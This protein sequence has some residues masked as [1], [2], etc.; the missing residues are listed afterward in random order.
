MNRIKYISSTFWKPLLTVATLSMLLVMLVVPTNLYAQKSAISEA[1]KALQANELDKSRALM[2]SASTHPETKDENKTWYY[3]AWVYKKLYSAKEAE[4]KESPYRL[5]AINSFKR[6][7]ELDTVS[8]LHE[9]AFKSTKYLASTLYNDAATSLNEGEFAL[10]QSNF[11]RYKDATLIIEPE[12]DFTS[13]EVQFYLV[14]GQQYNQ[15]YEADREANKSYFEKTKEAY[16]HVLEEDSMN[17]SA[18]YNL[19]ILYYNEAVNIIKNLDYDLDLITL[20]LIQDETVQLFANSL[21]YMV[22]AYR[23]DLCRI[24]TVIGLSGIYFSLNDMEKSQKIQEQL[25]HLK[26]PKVYENYSG[27]IT[28]ESDVNYFQ[29]C[30]STPKHFFKVV[31]G[32][33]GNYY[34][35]GNDK[36][37]FN[38]TEYVK[39]N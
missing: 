23:L 3:R 8:E 1:L 21:P 34:R 5:E 20:E 4:N 2:D 10:A 18:N 31:K 15:L 27:E 33:D 12:H 25:E 22:R 28:E 14:M 24:E 39:T 17:L 38:G 6:F 30:I 16:S 36:Y 7:F 37:V 35:V 19:G 29:E 9:T 11:Q 13:L 32:D 26:N